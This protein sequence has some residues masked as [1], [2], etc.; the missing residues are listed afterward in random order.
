D[1]GLQVGEAAVRMPGE[2]T[3]RGVGR[4]RAA[5]AVEDVAFA[6]RL[7][8]EGVEHTTVRVPELG[9]RAEAVVR[10]DVRERLH[11]AGDAEVTAIRRGVHA[12]DH[13]RR[14]DHAGAAVCGVHDGQ[15]A[16]RV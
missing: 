7:L 15:L 14:T 13:S 3:T 4:L 10:R 5:R 2:G 12:A 11:R 9:D 16:R 8:G 1:G 6:Q